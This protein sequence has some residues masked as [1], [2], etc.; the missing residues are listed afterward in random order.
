M[1]TLKTLGLHLALPCLLAVT[2]QAIP[3]TGDM[4]LSGKY[5]PQNS[6]GVLQTD[7]NNATQIAFGRTY[8]M[9]VTG[10]FASIPTMT[11]VT[12]ATPLVYSPITV[13]VMPLWTVT[14]NGNTFQFKL[15][16]LAWSGVLGDLGAQS[17][18]LSGTG[19]VS[20]VGLGDYEATPGVWQGTFNASGTNFTWHNTTHAD[21]IQPSTPP[22]TDVP[23]GASTLVLL[24][25]ILGLL[26][27]T[28]KFHRIA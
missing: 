11:R 5:T 21:D 3:I 1:K 14:S 28:R 23:E 4:A 15:D 2:A 16:T 19:M 10:S 27:F 26:A 9:D 12:M 22:V 6:S 7:L 8:V 20:Y 17:M 13:P 24:G 18:I 25:S